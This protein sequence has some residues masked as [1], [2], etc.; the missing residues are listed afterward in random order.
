MY[1]LGLLPVFTATFLAFLVLGSRGRD[2]LFNEDG[3]ARSIILTSVYVILTLW[4]LM[5]ASLK[6]MHDLNL[7]GRDYF[8]SINPIRNFQ[9][10]RRLISEPGSLVQDDPENT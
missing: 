10:G 4:P 5:V 7:R 9:L 3:Q 6:R 8:F 1:V 2:A